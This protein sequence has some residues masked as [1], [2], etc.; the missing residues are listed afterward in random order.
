MTSPKIATQEQWLEARMKLYAK[1]K[2]LLDVRDSVSAER[3]ELPWVRMDKEYVFQSTEG[4]VTLLDLF[5][6]R[7]QLIVYHFMLPSMT[8]GEFCRSCSFWVD[9][10]GHLAHFHA[11]DTTVVLDCPV[12]LES[13]V[14]FKERMGWSIPWYSSLGTDF[15][16]DLFISRESGTMMPGISVFIREGDSVY[17]TYST[18]EFGGEM[19]NGTNHYLDLT[20]L[21]R[22]EEGLAWKHDWVRYHDAYEA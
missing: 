2:D 11:R 6:G 5:D 9:N 10:I 7:R 19:L 1:E 22:Q 8:G 21:G 16:T 20:P 18:L 13:I 12:P 15:Y 14:E 17:H 3:R 4:E